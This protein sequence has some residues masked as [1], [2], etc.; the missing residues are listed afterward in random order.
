MTE[1]LRGPGKGDPQLRAALKDVLAAPVDDV[2]WDRLH[3]QIMADAWARGRRRPERAFARVAAWS[4]R[5]IPLAA[6]ALVAAALALWIAPPPPARTPPPEF[7]PVAQELISA[8]PEET[9]L[10]LDAGTD[11]ESLLRAMS[12]NDG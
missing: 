2:D 9:R 5:G 1:D 3:G 12:V 7:W 10:L 11:V 6:A 8:L 4:P